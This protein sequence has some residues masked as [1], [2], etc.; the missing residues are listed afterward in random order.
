MIRGCSDMQAYQTIPSKDQ[1]A[2]PPQLAVPRVAQLALPQGLGSS[3]SGRWMM[4][5]LL[6]IWQS[7]MGLNWGLKPES[8]QRKTHLL[9]IFSLVGCCGNWCGQWQFQHGSNYQAHSFQE[10]LQP[11]RC[12]LVQSQKNQQDFQLDEHRMLP[13]LFGSNHQH[14]RDVPA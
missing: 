1:S 12:R 11:L 10:T 4:Q 6:A 2:D 14:W 5:Q 7:G 8:W 3:R 9:D 13:S